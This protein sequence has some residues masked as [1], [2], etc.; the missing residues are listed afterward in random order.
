SAT[1]AFDPQPSTSRMAFGVPLPP[2]SLQPTTPNP[3][4]SRQRLFTVQDLPTRRD[5]AEALIHVQHAA[6]QTSLLGKRDVVELQVLECFLEVWDSHPSLSPQT[7]LRIFDR[8][9]LF[10]HVAMSG[11]GQA[12]DGYADPSATFLLG[13]PAPRRP[14]PRPRDQPPRRTSPARR[15]DTRFRE[16]SPKKTTKPSDPPK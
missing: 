5:L 9:R 12:L 2:P 14:D 1:T 3:Y 6:K 7:K 10:Y 8:V 16:Q 4:A 11:W 15:P 13:P